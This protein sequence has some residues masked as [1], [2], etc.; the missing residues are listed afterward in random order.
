MH[1]HF[2]VST[3]KLRKVF[4]HIPG[5]F[6]S[7]SAE[8]SFESANFKPG[9]ILGDTLRLWQIRHGIPVPILEP[10]A[11]FLVKASFA[12]SKIPRYFCPFAMMILY[13]Q[14]RY[15]GE[16]NFISYINPDQTCATDRQLSN[17]PIFIGIH[18]MLSCTIR[19]FMKGKLF[20]K[21]TYIYVHISLQMPPI[22]TYRPYRYIRIYSAI[23]L[24]KRCGRRVFMSVN[25]PGHISTTFPCSTSPC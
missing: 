10:F 15:A 6:F 3:P 5:D 12:H 1:P 13:I 14:Y 8:S 16:D 22:H 7:E 25:S 18:R 21:D 23:V 4:K 11:K 24:E 2:H 20:H 9:Q 19:I 17:Q